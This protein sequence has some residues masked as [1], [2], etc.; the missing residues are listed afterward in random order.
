MHL[1]LNLLFIAGIVIAVLFFFPLS[2]VVL[3]GVLALLLYFL[4]SYIAFKKQHPN[5]IIIFVVNLLFGFT[6]II[7]IVCLI[8]AIAYQPNVT[9]IEKHYYHA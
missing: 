2:T 9:I 3:L 7:W 4:P 6:F 8:L 5:S 1:L